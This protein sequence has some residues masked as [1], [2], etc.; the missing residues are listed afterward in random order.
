M[1]K[2]ADD[3]DGVD[4]LFFQPGPDVGAGEGAVDILLKSFSGEAVGWGP[5]PGENSAPQVL[6]M[7]AGDSLGRL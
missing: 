2:E 6:G 7:K 1:G 5:Q 3:E 4:L